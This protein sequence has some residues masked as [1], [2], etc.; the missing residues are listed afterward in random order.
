MRLKTNLDAVDFRM[1]A[2]ADRFIVLDSDRAFVLPSHQCR[3]TWT[4]ETVEDVQAVD[5]SVEESQG[6]AACEVGF[7]RAHPPLVLYH[8][9]GKVHVSL[10]TNSP[11]H[12]RGSTIFGEC[13]KATTTGQRRSWHGS[14]ARPE[15]LDRTGP[16][17]AWRPTRLANPPRWRLGG[18]R[19]PV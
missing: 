6:G 17:P 4:Q 14:P 2:A 9:G 19:V 16:C 3:A 7:Q 15:Q 11:I 5:C 18:A 1:T 8:S 13:M 10:Q 12:R